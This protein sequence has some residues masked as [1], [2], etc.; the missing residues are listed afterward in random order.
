MSE[1]HTVNKSPF[2]KSSVDSC[3]AHV[4]EGSAVLFYEDAVYAAMEGTSVSSKVKAAAG[5]KL[6]ALGPDVAARGIPADR[7]IAGVEVIDYAGFVDLS[8]QHSK[9]VAWV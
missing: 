8:V 5:V 4:Q 6:Y 1:L 3:L 2:E 7:L 9:V